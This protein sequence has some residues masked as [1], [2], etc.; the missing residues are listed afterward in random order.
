M[1]SKGMI[2]G[3]IGATAGVT[4]VPGGGWRG[5]GCLAGRGCGPDRAWLASG[6]QPWVAVAAHPAGLV[7]TG[8][9][10]EQCHRGVP[11][12]DAGGR[13][14]GGAG[15]PNVGL[16]HAAAGVR[17]EPGLDRH[18]AVLSG[19]PVP[20]AQQRRGTSATRSQVVPSPVTGC[21]TWWM[22]DRPVGSGGVP[23]ADVSECSCGCTARNRCATRWL[24][25]YR[26]TARC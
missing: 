21:G 11:G 19:H 3:W 2:A 1:G 8:L 6:R 12:R 24:P 4:A 23:C 20:A 25:V 13:R 10:A 5:R 9:P 17:T 7:R 14:P 26:H 15:V 18:P 22:T 16:G